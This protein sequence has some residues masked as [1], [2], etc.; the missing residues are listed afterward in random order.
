MDQQQADSLI[1][2]SASGDM[3]SFRKLV[4]MHQSFVFAIAFRM[5]CDE[6]DTEE[7][8]QDTFVRVWKNLSR[9]NHEM[10]FSTWLYKIAVNL[11]YDKMRSRKLRL[12]HV[13]FSIEGLILG[14]LPSQENVETTYIN[15]EQA[16]I[17]RYLTNTLSPQQRIVFSLSELEELSVEEISEITGMTPNKIKSNLYCAKQAI[18]KKL[19]KIE[20]RRTSY[21]RT[22]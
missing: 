19:E 10:R 7:V 14:N 16:E 11:C 1:I 21:E 15:R 3:V 17:I 6:P 18:R 20:E 13:P 9:F 5:L 12:N 4:E 8:V 22:L 2:N